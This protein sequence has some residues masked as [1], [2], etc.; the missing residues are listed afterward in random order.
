MHKVKTHRQTVD[1]SNALKMTKFNREK[2]FAQ[3]NTANTIVIDTFH[4]LMAEQIVRHDDDNSFWFIQ[5]GA[6]TG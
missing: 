6:K 2:N 5:E 4:M 3:K 1:R